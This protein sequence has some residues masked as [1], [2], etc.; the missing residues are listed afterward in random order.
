MKEKTFN[1]Y[2]QELRRIMYNLNKC[3][4]LLLILMFVP[5]Q[6]S[7]FAQATL[8]IQ[9]HG[10]CKTR[11]TIE[12]KRTLGP[13]SSPLGYGDVQEFSKNSK[14]DL[15]FM[16][17][18]NHSVWYQ[19]VS[20]TSGTMSFEIDPLDS[21]NDYDF[22]L[23]KY[24]GAHFCDNVIE[25]KQL[26]I[27][28]NFSRNKVELGGKTGLNK[29]AKENFVSQGIQA[30]YSN[31]IPV[32]KGDTFVLLV[33]GVYK[34]SLG[35][36]LHF[37]YQ[38]NRQLSTDPLPQRK[39][40]EKTYTEE[41]TLIRWGGRVV[42]ENNQ[43]LGA[44][45][46]TLRDV[47]TKE[48]IAEGFSDAETGLYGL[49]FFTLEDALQDPLY[50]EAQRSG[51]LFTD[52]IINPYELTQ[53]LK[54]IPL[55]L[56]LKKLKKG[57]RFQLFDV[58]FQFMSA[59]PLTR[60]QSCLDALLK[61][62]QMHESLNIRIEGHANGCCT[63]LRAESS[64]EA[65]Q[66]ISNKRADAIAQFLIKNGIASDRLSIIGYGLTRMLYENKS[67]NAHLNRRIEIEVLDF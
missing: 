59:V 20:K 1:I 62:M 26:P 30:A 24:T 8:D 48:L 6:N 25:K 34:N 35:H 50:I 37:G 41:P 67:P 15:Y 58:G 40:K 44:A 61:T 52:T 21:L 47:N 36:N 49:I 42:D 64:E 13:S 12:T 4:L 56:K 7:I 22:A 28:T 53:S 2:L 32:T 57:R 5:T 23:Y 51:Y 60:S 43:Y 27:R 54:H 65:A 66:E 19:F 31:V 14:D 63:V 16:E 33:N 9:G 10:D 45:H 17:N 11:L 55:R 29:E 39:P 18:E 46:V 38:S 3:F